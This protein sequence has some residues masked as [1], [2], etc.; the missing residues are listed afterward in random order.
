MRAHVLI[1][2]LYHLIK[3]NAGGESSLTKKLVNS[4]MSFTETQE[5]YLNNLVILLGGFSNRHI[6]P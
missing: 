3:I 6:Y 5:K 2:I 4:H 1:L